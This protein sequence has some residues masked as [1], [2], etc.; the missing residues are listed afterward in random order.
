MNASEPIVRGK[1]DH[2]G[3]VGLPRSLRTE[4]VDRSTRQLE[5]IH[6]R[7]HAINKWFRPTRLLN[8]LDRLYAIALSEDHDR[9]RAAKV[10][11]DTFYHPTKD[12]VMP[13]YLQQ[14]VI[15]LTPEKE[16]EY[17]E[18]TRTLLSEKYGHG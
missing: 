1:G 7:F 8:V 17:E 5:R 3:R 6:R 18:K 16:K 2:G 11:I 14:N 4:L 10:L 13:Q 15:L 9:V 12:P